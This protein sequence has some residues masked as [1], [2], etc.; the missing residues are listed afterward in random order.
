MKT[1]LNEANT[2]NILSQ[3]IWFKLI[4]VA[5]EKHQLHTKM[6]LMLLVWNMG[7]PITIYFSGLR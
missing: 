7:R 5:G 6:D 4:S 2:G 3:G 1:R